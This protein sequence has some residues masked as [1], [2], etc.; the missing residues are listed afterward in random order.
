MH[1]SRP[2]R[3]ARLRKRLPAPQKRVDE[4]AGDVSRA[5]MNGHARGLVDDDYGSRLS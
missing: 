5:G 2:Q 3:I 1:D 4:R